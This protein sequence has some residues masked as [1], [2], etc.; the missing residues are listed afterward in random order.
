MKIVIK[1]QLWTVPRINFILSELLS[2]H[3]VSTVTEIS[4]FQN[5]FFKDITNKV[6]FWSNHT[7]NIRLKFHQKPPYDLDISR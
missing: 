2:A 7:F 4:F 3:L 6:I 5:Q 1:L